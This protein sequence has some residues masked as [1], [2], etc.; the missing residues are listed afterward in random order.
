M[1]ALLC[2]PRLRGGQSVVEIV[3]DQVNLDVVATKDA[4]FLDF[5]LRRRHRHEDHTLHAQM[6]AH[7]R[8]ALRMVARAGADEQ[9]LPL[10][11]AHS[12][13]RTA[14]LVG[15]HRA[16]V[17]ALE[18]DVRAIAVGQ[19]G[20]PLQTEWAG[21]TVRIACSAARAR[22]MKSVMTRFSGLSRLKGQG[23]HM[24]TRIKQVRVFR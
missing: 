13:E 2:T 4:G 1:P 14:D 21:N 11:L 6:L 19:M 8:H 10:L 23:I 9:F 7:I 15:P 12:V 24:C 22:V 17:L 20:I 3:A 5:L 18:P 16:E